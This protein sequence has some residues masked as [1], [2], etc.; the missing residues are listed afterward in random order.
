MTST[1]NKIRLITIDLDDTVWPCMPVIQRA[2]RTLHD[3]L[4]KHAP[5]LAAQY[6]VDLLREHR[7]QLMLE[8]PDISHNL[9][10]SRQLSLE[11]LLRSFGYDPLLSFDAIEIFRHERNR[12]TPFDEVIHSLNDLRQR[13]TLISVTNGN[14]EVENTPLKDLFHHSLTAADVGAAKPDPA[15]FY[16]AMRLADVSAEHTLHVGDD[17]LT[18]IEAARK[19]DIPAVWMNRGNT[20]WPKTL[21]QP[22]WVIRDLN[23]LTRLIF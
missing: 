18:D 2:E 21:R 7:R 22:D 16:E 8:R 20:E 13:A 19:A 9:T 1:L 10:L 12:V 3:W 5:M 14:A 6:N 23:E 17:P 4:S 15:I 11:N